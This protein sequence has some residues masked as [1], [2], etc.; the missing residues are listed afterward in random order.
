MNQA[1]TKKEKM[2]EAK[3]KFSKKLKAT[4]NGKIIKK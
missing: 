2:L 3:K 4:T 1:T